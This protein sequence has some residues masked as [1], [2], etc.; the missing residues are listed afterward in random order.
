VDSRLPEIARHKIVSAAQRAGIMLKQTYAKEGK[1][2]RRK[3]GG[4]AHAKQVRRLKRI[5]K[6]QRTILGVVMREAQRK[7]DAQAKA[8]AGSGHPERESSG[9]TALSDL[10]LWLERAERIRTQRR[11]DKNK[12]YALHAPEA[13]GSIPG[14]EST[15]STAW[16]T[17]QSAPIPRWPATASGIADLP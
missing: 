4:Y 3:A 7:L 16:V 15:R 8:V 17:I 10:H 13:K 2:L 5:V 9:P 12:L 1:V 11:H 6:R 14:S